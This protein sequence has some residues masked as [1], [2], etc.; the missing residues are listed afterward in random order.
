MLGNQEKQ[1]T[2]SSVLKRASISPTSVS[3]DKSAYLGML[4]TI[5]VSTVICIGAALPHTF[6]L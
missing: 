4:P 2:C 1:L 6:T 3:D 5:K